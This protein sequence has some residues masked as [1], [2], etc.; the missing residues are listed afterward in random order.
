MVKWFDRIFRKDQQ[1]LTGE[2]RS[3]LDEALREVDI[4]NP[5]VRLGFA[6]IEV[7]KPQFELLGNR[8]GKFPVRL[9]YTADSARGAL[10]GTAL[11]IAMQEYDSLPNE[12]AIDA[13]IAAFSY[14]FGE[15]NGKVM[16][17]KAFEE[18]RSG[19]EAINKAADFAIGDTKIAL[20]NGAT[21]AAF[22]HAAQGA[23]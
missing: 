22:F 8:E 7:L 4:N 1:S 23:L 14:A 16:A 17:F 9:P 21:P 5:E 6:A 10:L 19:N 20:A 3:A 12:I 11:A 13:M 18:S 2:L 15:E